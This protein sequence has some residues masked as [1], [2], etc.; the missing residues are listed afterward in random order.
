MATADRLPPHDIAAEESVLGSLLIDGAKAELVAAILQ[1]PEFY[2]E[3]NRWVYE[4]CLSL[5][6][7]GKPI[8]TTTVAHALDDAGKL[9]DIGGAAYLSHL[10]GN[11]PTSTH[12]AYYAEL[13]HEH[14]EQRRYIT[15]AGHLADQAYGR[16]APA[17]IALSLA[18]Q[19]R[20][21][22]RTS[23]REEMVKPESEMDPFGRLW[24]RWP[25]NH[26]DVE[27]EQIERLSG[28]RGGTQA[29]FAIQ[30]NGRRPIPPFRLNIHSKNQCDDHKKRLR[31]LLPGTDVE[32]FVDHLCSE[33]HNAHT[34]GDSISAADY[35]PQPEPPWLARPL[36][37]DGVAN[38]LF[39]DGGQGKTTIAVAICVSLNAGC[40][41]VPGISVPS[42]GLPT[43]FI[44]AEDTQDGILRIANAIASGAGLLPEA[45]KERFRYRRLYGPLADNMPAIQRD[46]EQYGIRACFYDSLITMAAGNP[47]ETDTPRLFFASTT[48]FPNCAVVGLSHIA[49][50]DTARPIASV[51]Y[52]NIPRNVWMA[53]FDKEAGVMGLY[54]DK[55]N[56]LEDN[57]PDPLYLTLDKIPTGVAYRAVSPAEAPGLEKHHSASTLIH[58]E[59]ENGSRTLEQLREA[60]PKSG[61]AIRAALKRETDAGRIVRLD[62]GEYGL[63]TLV[64]P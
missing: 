12:A 16:E 4:A 25:K 59:L 31:T 42:G 39:A 40:S 21:F 6:E 32:S 14:A 44:D 43:L 58:T 53:D 51:M 47:N 17:S 50:S 64:T 48:I 1:P 60:I 15:Y 10:T 24:L 33:V 26:L 18:D 62:R 27:I 13:V 30:S 34:G 5:H 11:L 37:M 20:S 29:L 3:R 9:A 36:V 23:A 49:K 63:V 22:L 38:V 19:S 45:W 41:L 35:E 28:S 55:V 7:L 57:D 52:R 56:S 46:V 61:G 54:P 8:D 2:R